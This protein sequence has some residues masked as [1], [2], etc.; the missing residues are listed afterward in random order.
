SAAGDLTVGQNIEVNGETFAAV[1]ANATPTNVESNLGTTLAETLANLASQVNASTDT[2]VSQAAYSS[3]ANQLI[4]THDSV[5]VQGNAF[6]ITVG[7]S[8]GAVSGATLTNG[9]QGSL[10]TNRTDFSGT[11]GDLILQDI[12]GEK[13]QGSIEF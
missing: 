5:G 3:N 4:I 2:A 8:G 6:T 11:L 7:T 13:A 10:S 1:A 12:Q 9:T